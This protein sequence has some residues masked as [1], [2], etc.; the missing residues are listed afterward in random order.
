MRKLF[1]LFLLLLIG[2]VS[3]SAAFS[4]VPASHSNVVAIE[5]V[6]SKGIVAGYPDGTFRPDNTINRAELSKIIIE[7]NFTETEIEDCISDNTEDSWSYVF[8]PDV[9]KGE[10]FDDYICIAKAEGIVAGYPDNTFQPANSVNFAEA[11]KIISGAFGFSTSSDEVWYKPFVE[12]LGNRKA[13][14]TTITSFDK[15]ITRGEMAEM[16]WRIKT[17]NQNEESLSYKEILNP[18]PVPYEEILN[19]VS[20]PVPVPDDFLLDD[21]DL[22]EFLD[23]LDLLNELF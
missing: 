15:N 2:T 3:V 21:P 13:I 10:W 16:I 17:N 18:V 4:D 1:C 8:F 23:A 20:V 5:Y 7:A 12:E 6:Q 11:A 14:P 9:K 19:P 22:N